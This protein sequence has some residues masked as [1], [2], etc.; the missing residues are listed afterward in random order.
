MVREETFRARKGFAHNKRHAFWDDPRKTSWNQLKTSFISTTNAFINSLRNPLVNSL[1]KRLVTNELRPFIGLTGLRKDTTHCT[2]R[3][4][5][6]LM[7]L[8]LRPCQ[9]E[10]SS[11]LHQFMH[12]FLLCAC[13]GLHRTCLSAESP[14]LSSRK[15]PWVG[16]AQI[17]AFFLVEFFRPSS[18]CCWVLANSID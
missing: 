11:T 18:S 17:L 12:Q 5:S 3:I 1:L 4:N 7:L 2:D 13:T 9:E 6:L 16:I 14:K 8:R 15:L 10:R